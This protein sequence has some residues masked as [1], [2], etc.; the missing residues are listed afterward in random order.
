M[1]L[2][3]PLSLP[4][5]LLAGP[6]TIGDGTDYIKLDPANGKIDT[7]GTASPLTVS[8]LLLDIW[9]PP[10]TGE[11]TTG[12]LNGAN[13]AGATAVADRLY[14]VPCV[15]PQRGTF[16]AIMIHA[17]TGG[18]GANARMGV[19]DDDYGNPGDLVIDAGAFTPTA[20]AFYELTFG[21]SLTLGP[22]IVWLTLVTDDAVVAW[23]RSSSTSALSLAIV[24]SGA[25][26][27]PV[28]MVYRSF[29]LAELPDSFGEATRTLVGSPYRILLK[30]A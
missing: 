1:I 4:P 10:E 12:L 8:N 27:A 16:S 15:L 18:L 5:D 30:G 17:D 6:R 11:Y 22:G 29:A 9:R 3:S 7:A 28:N 20:A 24:Q 26:S 21:S 19:Y 14:A 23:E 2:R 13:A 25:D